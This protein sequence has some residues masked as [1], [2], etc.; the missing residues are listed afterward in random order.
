MDRLEQPP[1]SERA[2]PREWFRASAHEMRRA[3]DA[4]ILSSSE[5][6]EV[7][8]ERVREFDP[9]LRAFSEV[10]ADQARVE[11]E[12][13]DRERR[14]GEAPNPLHG[15]PISVKE[16]F[17]FEGRATTL[18]V[19]TRATH[20]AKGDSAIVSALKRAGAILVGRGN[21]GQMMFTYEADNP[22]FGRTSNPFSARHSSGG[23]SGG[24]A[25]ALA[26]GLVPLAVGSDLGGSIRVPAH[27]CGISGLR[28]TP[29]RWPNR[30]M[31]APRAGARIVSIQSGPMAR[32]ASDVAF[33]FDAL[34]PA[35]L[36]ELDPGVPP[37][38]HRQSKPIRSL[39]V[40]FFTDNGL[41]TPSSAIVAAVERAADALRAA[42]VF[43][44][45]FTPPGLDSL[46]YELI[47]LLGADGG[48]E[49]EEMLEDSPI[50][51]SLKPIRDLARMPKAMRSGL[52]SVGKLTGDRELARLVASVGEKSGTRIVEIAAKLSSLRD[53]VQTAMA[54]QKLD[55]LLCPAYATPAVPHGASGE[56]LL[57]ASHSAVFN[58][59][60]FPAGVVPVT[61]V[62]ATE[63]RRVD[64]SGRLGR[65]ARRIDEQSAGLPVGVQVA[66]LPWH[67]EEVLA[68]LCAI[69]KNVEGDVD[70][71]KTPINPA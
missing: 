4:G 17:D 25:A 15:L 47:A 30:G 54:E 22:L 3:L 70:F 19:S 35:V 50:A 63:A 66:A 23:S 34:D 18:G 40:G 33:L 8:L 32:S 68:L 9:K 10:F 29:S 1:R 41:L 7:H 37:V 51:E 64:A 5:L 46:F 43:V 53:D 14:A 21:L 60:G 24:D 36:H 71:P 45:R 42:G 61:R 57:G 52:A 27:S 58:A 38:P 13:A 39:R 12:R 20:R 6:L 48:N 55:A 69:E 62:H 31:L 67:D 65:L 26:A 28:P 59:L 49:L 2:E 44:T 11:A 16:C 56:L